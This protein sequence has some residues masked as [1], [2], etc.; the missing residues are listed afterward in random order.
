MASFKC[1]D[2]GESGLVG[3]RTGNHLKLAQLIVARLC[4]Q[5]YMMRESELRIKLDTR[6]CIQ[7]EKVK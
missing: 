7:V 1:M 5:I 6:S 4:N 2:K 3:K